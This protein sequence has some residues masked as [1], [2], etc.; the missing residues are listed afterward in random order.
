MRPLIDKYGPKLVG[1][2]EIGRYFGEDW[3][4]IQRLVLTGRFPAFRLGGR[5]I[6]FERVIDIWVAANLLSAMSG[7]T[8]DPQTVIDELMAEVAMDLRE[9]Q[10]HINKRSASGD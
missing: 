3:R 1:C 7:R 5:V 2:E 6:S 4:L 9:L 10:A 8:L